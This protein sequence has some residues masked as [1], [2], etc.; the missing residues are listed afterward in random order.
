MFRRHY[1]R[2]VDTIGGA[3]AELSRAE[4]RVLDAIDE[5]A[6]VDELVAMIRVPSITGSDAES[7]LQH[8]HARELAALGFDV[9][10]WKLDLDQLA[11][12][13]C[14]PGTEAVRTEGYG[15]V[16]VLGP[17]GIP[18]LVL[19][20]HVDV[21]PTGDPAGW[22]RGDPWSGAIRRKFCRS[23]SPLRSRSKASA[24]SSVEF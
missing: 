8:W 20:A 15:V 5:R 11:S 12:H 9:D 23:V 17:P 19:Q 14:H 13:P 10:H 7:D 2:A 22:R 24:S 4:M 21:V 16:G 18:A 1:R 6:L 3:T